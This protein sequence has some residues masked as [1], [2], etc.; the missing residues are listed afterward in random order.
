MV[1]LEKVPEAEDLEMALEAGAL[2]VDGLYDVDELVVPLFEAGGAFDLLEL[3]RGMFA[4][5]CLLRGR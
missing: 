3:K 1:D 4:V 2:A 5:A